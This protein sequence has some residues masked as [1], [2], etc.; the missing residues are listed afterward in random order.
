MNFTTCSNNFL[1]SGESL[2]RYLTPGPLLEDGTAALEQVRGYSCLRMGKAIKELFRRPQ[3]VSCCHH[4]YGLLSDH[5]RKNFEWSLADTRCQLQ[6]CN[7]KLCWP[8]W[9]GTLSRL[10][11][12]TGHGVDKVVLLPFV[13][14]HTGAERILQRNRTDA[15]LSLYFPVLTVVHKRVFSQVRQYSNL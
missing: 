10:C 6:A 4:T 12:V 2:P 7:T 3:A 15:F 14:L 1:E 11:S 8:G 5:W 13:V 9:A